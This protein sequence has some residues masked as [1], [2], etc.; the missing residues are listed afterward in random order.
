M[1]SIMGLLEPTASVSGSIIFNDVNLLSLSEAQINQ[2]RSDKISIIF[3][4]PM[5]SLNPFLTIGSQL[6]EVLIYHKNYSKT[7]A[8][9]RSIE[10]LELVQLDNADTLMRRYPHEL[11]GGMRQR[12]AIA[13][14]LLCEPELLIADEATTALDVIVQS[15][16]LALLKKLKKQLDMTIIMITHDLAVISECCDDVMIMHQGELKEIGSVK[17][18]FKQPSD[19]YTKQLLSAVPKIKKGKSKSKLLQYLVE[20]QSYLQINL[21]FICNRN[22]SLEN[23]LLQKPSIL[24][25]LMFMKAKH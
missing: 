17:T 18:I 16:I 23:Q 19:I 10:F 2:V 9:K 7:A 21:V 3:Q 12:V 1:L 11:S 24:L 4:D 22:S 6:T 20:A 5:T 13:M 25:L 8:I 15:D 14:A